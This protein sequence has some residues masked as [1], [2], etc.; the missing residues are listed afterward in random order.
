MIKF[1]VYEYMHVL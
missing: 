1:T